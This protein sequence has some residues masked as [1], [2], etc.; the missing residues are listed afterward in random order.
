MLRRL[1]P[2]VLV[3]LA[4]S[5]A[6]EIGHCFGLSDTGGG[7]GVMGDPPAGAVSAAEAEAVWAAR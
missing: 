6:P 7:T 2:L 4:A 5:L 1:V 3:V